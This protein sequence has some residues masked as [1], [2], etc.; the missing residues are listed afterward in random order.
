MLKSIFIYDAP[1]AIGLDIRAIGYH[2][3]DMFPRVEVET[4]TDF[5]T[6]HLGQFDLD[7]VEA[8]T[9]EVAARLEER[10]VHNL[11]APDRRDDFEPETPEERE[12]GTVYL[13][14]PLQDVM[15]AVIPAEER[16]AQALHLAFITQCIG[17]FV[18][19]ESHFRLQ[20]V[21]HGEPTIISTTGIIEAPALPR[22]Y[23]FRRAQLLMFGL[24]AAAEELDGLFAEEALAHGDTRLN[25]VATGIALQAV[26]RHAFGE[27][28]C[29][30]PTCP[31]HVATTHDELARA[32]L[33]DDSRLCD[34][35]TR[36][37]RSARHGSEEAI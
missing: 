27:V 25:R 8:L 17:C 11:V 15:R 23:A 35:H 33:S 34:R 16:G 3:A 10:E 5:F 4:R 30:E 37:V 1:D 7:Q 19:G 2:L 29:A 12:L 32:H 21:Q 6:W 9:A 26:F 18:P 24:D 13:A 22:E 28:G 31:L 14:E 36:M 20:M